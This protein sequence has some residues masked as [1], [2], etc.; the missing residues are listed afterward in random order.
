MPHKKIAEMSGVPQAEH[1]RGSPLEF[2]VPEPAFHRAEHG[3]AKLSGEKID[4]KS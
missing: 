2:S 1:F 3:I 4:R